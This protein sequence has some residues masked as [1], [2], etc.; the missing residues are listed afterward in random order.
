MKLL[1]LS[2][3]HFLN[4]AFCLAFNDPETENCDPD[5]YIQAN[6]TCE[7]YENLL[8]HNRGE[9]FDQTLKCIGYDVFQ[10]PARATSQNSPT[11]VNF[12]LKVLK[13]E[14]LNIDTSVSNCL[15]DNFV[16]NYINYLFRS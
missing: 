3:I 9:N 8:T 14:S 15:L 7:M 4:S 13:I 2:I 16:I 1:K 12:A 11:I 10:D 5:K 6:W